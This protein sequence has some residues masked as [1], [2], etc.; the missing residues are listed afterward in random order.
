[1]DK[2]DIEDCESLLRES[3]DLENQLSPRD[4]KNRTISQCIMLSLCCDVMFLT[5]LCVMRVSYAQF[6]K[7]FTANGKIP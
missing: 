5:V 6:G 7:L 3:L 2:G 1:M 4:E